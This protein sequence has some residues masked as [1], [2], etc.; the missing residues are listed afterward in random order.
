VLT[1]RDLFLRLA[2][3]PL[4]AF[5]SV[6]FFYTERWMDDGF[7]FGFCYAVAIITT[8]VFWQLNRYILLECRQRMPRFEQTAQ[9]ISIQVFMAV[10]FSGSLSVLVSFI[11]DKTE[12]WGRAFRWQDYVYN[13]ITALSFVVA[14]IV[15]Y[16]AVFYFVRWRQST[17]EAEKLKEANL[18]SQ[19]ESLKNQVS[20]HFLFNSLN[21]LSSLIEENPKEAVRFVNQLSRVYRY[22]LQSNEKKLTTLKEELDFL[23]AYFFLLKT[24]FGAGVDLHVDIPAEKMQTL[25]PPLTLQ[26]LVENA[27]KHNVVSVNRPLQ[28]SL[29][30]NEEGKIVIRNNLQ[31]KTLNVISSGMGLA[32]ISAKYKLMN[33]PGL[34]VNELPEEFEVQLPIIPN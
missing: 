9:R 22:L 4:V 17:R 31:K 13:A 16:E 2:G 19:L 18:Q 11:Y 15:V 21:T 12:F 8:Y 34:L 1:L 32:N 24:R 28:I 27:V 10:L 20:P 23:Q 7:S 5:L 33:K 26:I 14:L 30:V 29:V 25:I 3:I 6:F